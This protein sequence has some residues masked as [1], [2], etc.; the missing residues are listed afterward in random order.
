MKELPLSIATGFRLQGMC[1]TADRQFCRIPWSV[2]LS[3]VLLTGVLLFPLVNSSAPAIA[4]TVSWENRGIEV[5]TETANEEP[6]ANEQLHEPEVNQARKPDLETTPRRDDP[7]YFELLIE[8][9]WLH[10]QG[11][12]AEAEH[13]YRKAKGSF[14]GIVFS[15]RPEPIDDPM[16]LPPAGQ[17]YWREAQAGQESGLLTRI[18][19][20]LELLVQNY[21]EFVPATVRYAD[22]LLAQNRSQEALAVLERAVTLYPDQADLVRAK[23][24][25]LAVQEEWL[26]ASIAARQ[27]ALLY[28]DHPVANEFLTLA[29]EHQHTFRAKLRNRL[30]G[31]AI[32]N[33]FTGALSFALTGGLL[34]PISAIDTAV[35]LLRGEAQVGESIAR[36]AQRQ[37]DL[38][39][40]PAVLAY[41]NSIGQR[42]A[43][44]TGRDEFEYEFFV[45]RHPGLNAFALPGGKIFI[46]AGAI[47]QTH[48]EAELAGLIAHEIAHSALSHGFQLVTSSNVTASIFLPVPY[49]GALATDLTV[50]GY[51]R[52][53]ER[54]ADAFGT[55]LLAASGYDHLMLTLE[56]QDQ[57]PR[58]L[59]WLSTHPDIR[60][61]IQNIAT[62]IE[63]NGYNRYTY[64]GVEPHRQIQAQVISLL[65]EED[66]ET[67]ESS[68]PNIRR[69]E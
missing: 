37:L 48:S 50:L 47:V 29:D 36:D 14:T 11:R 46:N 43:D 4:Q 64:E 1:M 41:V 67:E 60:E 21:P 30:T 45:V 32:A 58:G 42:L 62:L 7:D 34:G 49:A 5:P 56:A 18:M 55:R 9:D 40:D 12:R 20:P 8:A 28:P 25:T 27:F 44:M 33:V 51:S 39:D 10:T 3:K 68:E 26:D 24:N 63:E 2:T 17:V 66:L 23:I 22:L 38:V 69:K 59:A 6:E 65:D 54:Q 52:D 53:M 13:R 19:V 15:N 35:L 61:R 57:G 16:Q 31:N